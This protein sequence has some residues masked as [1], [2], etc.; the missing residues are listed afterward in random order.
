LHCIAAVLDGDAMASFR[1]SITGRTAKSSSSRRRSENGHTDHQE[2]PL[3]VSSSSWVAQQRSWHQTRDQHTNGGDKPLDDATITRNIRS[4]LNKLTIERFDPLLVQLCSC[5]ISTQGHLQILMHEIMEK[6]TTQ[7]H[8]IPMYTDLCVV[9]QEWCTANQIGD[10]SQGSFKRILLTQCQNSFERYLKP[11]E[12]LKELQGEDRDEAE[13][14]YKTAMLGNIRFVGALLGKNMVGS[15]VILAITNAL[16]AKPIVPEALEC[17]AAFLTAVGSMFDG[18][19]DWKHRKELNNVFAELDRISQDT[20][21]VPARI[22]CL[23]S[24]V[25]D[26]RR[27]GWKDQKQAT[28]DLDGPM[29]L[30]EVQLRAE[31]CAGPRAADRAHG[32]RGKGWGS[33]GQETARWP[34]QPPLGGSKGSRVGGGKAAVTPNSSARGALTRSVDQPSLRPVVHAGSRNQAVAM[35][36]SGSSA[37]KPAE[38]TAVQQDEAKKI[39]NGVRAAVK[40]LCVVHDIPEAIQ[41]LRDMAIPAQYQAGELAHILA[42]VAE[43]G[44]QESRSVCFNFVVQL[45]VD[46]V[47]TKSELQPGL[48][49][50]FCK[51]F[52]ELFIDMPALPRIMRDEAI[53]TLEELVRTELLAA[54]QHAVYARR[55]M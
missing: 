42:Q 40:E 11:P 22:R 48:D 23:F 6:A 45:F 52:D 14:K 2:P 9:L 44:S 18:R 1:S 43:E 30:Q 54:E 7:H 27:A 41:R 15:Q 34:Q 39:K 28:K 20:E 50:F 33:G 51:S 16:L 26:L 37:E 38:K 12:F 31:Q 55:V 10:S 24:D 47:F 5:G 4:I 8:F 36:A 49:R 32:S 17:L 25:L 53:P 3:E 21:K 13:V 19:Q 46:C 29:T 35:Q